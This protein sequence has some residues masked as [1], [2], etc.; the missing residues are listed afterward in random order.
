MVLYPVM[1]L[2][3]SGNPTDFSRLRDVKC[4]RQQRTAALLELIHLSS[5]TLLPNVHPVPVK[6]M[7]YLQELIGQTEHL[8]I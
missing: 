6:L 8:S 2:F 1:Q 4:Q 5:S 3:Y 7:A